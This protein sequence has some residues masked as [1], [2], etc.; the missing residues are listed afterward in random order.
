MTNYEKIKSMTIDEM[1]NH[2]AVLQLC[3]LCDNNKKFDCKHSTCT[4][5][6]KKYLES[7]A[8]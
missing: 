6:I 1:I 7:E 5:G 8:E 2:F 3:D 4:G